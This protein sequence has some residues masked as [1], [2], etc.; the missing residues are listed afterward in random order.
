M[1]RLRWPDSTNSVSD[2][3]GTVQNRAAALSPSISTISR[4]LGPSGGRSGV[5]YDIFITDDSHRDPTNLNDA[6]ATEDPQ[7]VRTRH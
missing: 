2:D 1:S 3:P 5:R 4:L 6:T 7:N